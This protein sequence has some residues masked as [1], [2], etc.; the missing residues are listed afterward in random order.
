MN[1]TVDRENDLKALGELK[2]RFCV[3]AYQR[4]Y[5]WTKEH[6]GLLFE[7]LER[8]TEDKSSADKKNKHYF[9]QMIV[10]SR[11]LEPDFTAKTAGADDR[12][13][14]ID[15]QQRLTTAL[16]L[17]AVLRHKLGGAACTGLEFTITYDT[18]EPSSSLLV[19]LIKNPDQANTHCP[20]AIMD[21]YYLREVC[22]TFLK[23]CDG[24]DKEKL[25]R[26]HEALLK[27]S[28]VLWYDTGD[29]DREVNSAE[30][31]IRLN[32]GRI[33]LTEAELCRALLL[34]DK[35]A[36]LSQQNLRAHM[37][38]TMERELCRPD[39]R[40]FLGY[41]ESGPTYMEI[42][43]QLYFLKKSKK[44]TETHP[45]F[46]LLYEALNGR[47]ANSRNG[48][49]VQEKSGQEIWDE[50]TCLFGHMRR[51]YDDSPY[52]HRIG[53]LMNLKGGQNW[54][55]R[56]ETLIPQDTD[57]LIPLSE[58]TIKNGI[59]SAFHTKPDE[60]FYSQHNDEIYNL[61]LLFNIELTHRKR[62][63]FSFEQYQKTTWSLEHI[64]ARNVEDLPEDK[65]ESW[66]TEHKELIEKLTESPRQK[67]N[68]TDNGTKLLNMIYEILKKHDHEEYRK[69][70]DDINTYI[71]KYTGYKE[72]NIHGLYN[73]ALLDQSTN[74]SVNNRIFL[75]KQ[76]MI[77]EKL[78]EQLTTGSDCFL[79]PG[80]EAVFLRIL[81]EKK[82][83]KEKGNEL[84]FWS[85]TD[86]DNYKTL[87]K[88]VLK[89]FDLSFQER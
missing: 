10:V 67:D 76:S 64:E 15:G 40:A 11:N 66:I 71:N 45:L 72:S 65:Y 82:K 61:L 56:W 48:P 58:T 22:K 4:G 60:M 5:R 53:F 70:I 78:R 52:Y 55:K 29:Y 28:V 87:L 33:P 47:S 26:L 8:F 17:D 19:S 46:K 59:R 69:L 37:W 50:L 35:N 54:L 6:A 39:F 75:K 73:L 51:W 1:N 20:D 32:M 85:Q 79:L 21:E 74:S 83:E 9:L 30:H 41:P 42:L 14:L 16:L 49:Y 89:E 34:S 68:H 7:D 84:P 31:F 24:E 77:K 27:R 2:G 23:L 25:K 63:R 18:R 44:E 88:S 57:S 12:W 81:P 86:R 36:D 38:D 80:T 13:E 43:L 3:K 62:Q